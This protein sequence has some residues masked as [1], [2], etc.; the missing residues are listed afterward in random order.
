M[1][2]IFV[3]AIG[4]LV[5]TS[6]M[7]KESQA[8]NE[9]LKNQRISLTHDIDSFTKIKQQYVGEIESLKKAHA[10]MLANEETRERNDRL[11]IERTMIERDINNFTNTRNSLIQENKSLKKQI[12]HNDLAVSTSKYV[13]IV[14][15]KI[16]QTTYSLSLGEYVKNK[17]NDV[18]FEIPVDKSYYDNARVGQTITDPGLKIGSLI[19]DGDFSELKIKIVGKRVINRK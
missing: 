6:C 7:N 14:K 1:R 17:M 10:D 13:Y 3:F 2:K 8:L 9:V 19:M 4:L 5:M 12:E 16:H 18:V 15:I 11:I